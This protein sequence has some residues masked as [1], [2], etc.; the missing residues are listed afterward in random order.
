[1]RSKGTKRSACSSF[2]NVRERSSSISPRKLHEN[3]RLCRVKIVRHFVKTDD[4][5]DPKTPK[6]A[7]AQALQMSEK[8]HPR[9]R[10]ESRPKMTLN[11]PPKTAGC[12][13][14]RIQSARRR[15]SQIICLLLHV[16]RHYYSGPACLSAELAKASRV[17]VESAEPT[18][19]AASPFSILS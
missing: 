16:Y 10:L 19:P 3:D 15:P 11:L 14:M 7:P 18:R 12:E 1:M 17:W 6:E 13:I 2:T 4:R 9:F 8:G 5:W